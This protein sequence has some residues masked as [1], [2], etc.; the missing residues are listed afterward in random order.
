MQK[1]NVPEKNIV[2][3]KRNECTKQQTMQ[4]KSG[5][6]DVVCFVFELV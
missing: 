1:T 2:S 4:N 3:N 6:E 5:E